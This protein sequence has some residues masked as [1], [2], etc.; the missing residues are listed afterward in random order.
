MGIISA[1]FGIIVIINPFANLYFTQMIG[2]FMVL[3][4]VIEATYTILLKQR[5]KN[6]LKLLK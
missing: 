2:L 4:A 6:F 5:S 3:Y 1:L